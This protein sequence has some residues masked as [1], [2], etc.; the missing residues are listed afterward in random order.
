MIELIKEWTELEPE[1]CSLDAGGQLFFLVKRDDLEFW[2][3][4]KG[5]MP[6]MLQIA[7]QQAIE[8]RGWLL[9]IELN[10]KRYDGRVYR[11]DKG[12]YVREFF[13]KSDNA[14]RS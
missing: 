2:L 3:G 6:E 4:I 11:W 14:C 8:A 10:A 12:I 7:V 9:E 5:S 13:A 1:R